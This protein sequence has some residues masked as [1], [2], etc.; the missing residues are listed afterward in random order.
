MPI[1]SGRFTIPFKL[2]CSGG[3]AGTRGLGDAYWEIAAGSGVT[4]ITGQQ[5]LDHRAAAAAVREACKT[6]QPSP[7]GNRDLPMYV[8]SY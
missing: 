5:C 3:F 1:A 2:T 8:A 4:R 7:Y 6:T